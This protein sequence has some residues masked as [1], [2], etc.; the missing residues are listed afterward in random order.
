MEDR[1]V[2]EKWV[3]QKPELEPEERKG[4]VVFRLRLAVIA[5]KCLR[6]SNKFGIFV[7][8]P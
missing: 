1:S 2:E 3:G 4:S 6:R 7:L 5:F 8:S